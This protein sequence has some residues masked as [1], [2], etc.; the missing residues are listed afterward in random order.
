MQRSSGQQL[1]RRAGTTDT[2]A[3]LGE[4]ERQLDALFDGFECL[5]R[6]PA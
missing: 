6:E 1:T 2:G 4:L 5:V 3:T